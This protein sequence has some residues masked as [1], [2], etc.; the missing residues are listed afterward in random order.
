M[1]RKLF[2]AILLT[3]TLLG[4]FVA[5]RAS[6][7][8][9]HMVSAMDHLRLAK[10]ELDLA[11]ADKGGHRAKALELVNSAI[12]EVRLGIEYARTH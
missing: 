3:L 8:Q 4:G 6:A 9:P 10:K 12:D 5:G 1:T 11:L 7:A 2:V